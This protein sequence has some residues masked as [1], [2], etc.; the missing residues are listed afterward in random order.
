MVDDLLDVV[1]RPATLDDA[2]PIATVHIASWREAYT[3]VVAEDYLAGLDVT[4]RTAWWTEVLDGSRRGTSVWVAELEGQVVGFA[5][6]G[7]SL[8]EDADRDTLQIYTIYL[9][10]SFWGHGVA[11]EL[12]RTVLSAVPGGAT[13]TLWVLAANDRARHFY[14]RNG[15]VA[16]GVERLEEFGGD[17]LKEIRYRRG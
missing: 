14:R 10:P 16:D 5:S 12:M 15:F 7:P 2:A 17:R 3:G 13:V 1:I 8:D 11:R 9:E 6:L 4:A